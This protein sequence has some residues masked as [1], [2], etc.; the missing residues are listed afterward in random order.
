MKHF[1]HHRSLSRRLPMPVFL[2]D[3]PCR[4]SV[5]EWHRELWRDWQEANGRSCGGAGSHRDLQFAYLRSVQI[6]RRKSN[7]LMARLHLSCSR[8]ERLRAGVFR[9]SPMSLIEG[10]TA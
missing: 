6:E 7:F 4:C 8:E 1:L 10:R 3:P 5:K 9:G 2:V